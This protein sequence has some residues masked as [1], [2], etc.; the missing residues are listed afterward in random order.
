MHVTGVHII[1]QRMHRILKVLYTSV[2]K[3]HCMDSDTAFK[4]RDPYEL[5]LKQLFITSACNYLM[6]ALHV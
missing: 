6:C 2:A 1:M 4:I 3:Q 5:P